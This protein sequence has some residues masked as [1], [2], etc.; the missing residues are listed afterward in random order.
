VVD[1]LQ[2]MLLLRFEVMKIKGVR[3]FLYVKNS[4]AAKHNRFT[5]INHEF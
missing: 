4:V 3:I 2:F 1:K 5:V